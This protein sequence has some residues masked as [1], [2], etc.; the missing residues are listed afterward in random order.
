MAGTTIQTTVV[1]VVDG[2]TIKI[3]WNGDEENIRILALDT[4]ESRPGLSK[5][6]TPWGHKAKEE[7]EGLVS[8]GDTL[9][10]EFPGTECDQVCWNKYR[11]NYDRPLGF[12]YLDDGTDF[13][14]WHRV[15][16]SVLEQV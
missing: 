4:E 3:D 6:E 9:T 5:P 12:V 16:P 11:G 15:R 1:K 7:V 10:L 13:H 8:P 2:D 14:S